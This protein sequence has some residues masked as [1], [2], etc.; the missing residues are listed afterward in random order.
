MKDYREY[1]I[2]V[3]VGYQVKVSMKKFWKIPY[4]HNSECRT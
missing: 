1:L 3:S 4:G 2:Y